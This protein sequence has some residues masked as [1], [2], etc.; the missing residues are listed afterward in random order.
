[1]VPADGAKRP[2]SLH[3]LRLLYLNYIQSCLLPPCSLFKEGDFGLWNAPKLGRFV[4]H[5][6]LCHSSLCS[7]PPCSANKIDQGF[8]DT[9]SL[10]LR[11]QTVFWQ[12]GSCIKTRSPISQGHHGSRIPCCS[13]THDIYDR[14]DRDDRRSITETLVKCS[15]WGCTGTPGDFQF[16]VWLA[17]RL[18]QVVPLNEYVF[19]AFVTSPPA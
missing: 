10:T 4:C 15:W 17:M 8:L 16:W 12:H 11:R 13:L 14:D 9:R 3:C 5:E 7:G 18:L 19:D 1:M 6:L 2:A